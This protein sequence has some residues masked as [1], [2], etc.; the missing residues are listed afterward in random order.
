MKASNGRSRGEEF[1]RQLFHEWKS[2][3]LT[4]QSFCEQK[5]IV[6]SSFY[7]WKKK[8]SDQ[9]CENKPSFIELPVHEI[10]NQKK[11]SDSILLSY[12]NFHIELSHDFSE[13]SVSKLLNIL[14]GL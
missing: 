13:E 2:S 6:L 9:S 10:L 5:K 14:K 12:N 11:D 3:G 7:N 1:W 4:I 8:L